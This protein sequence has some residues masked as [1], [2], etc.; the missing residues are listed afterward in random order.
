MAPKPTLSDVDVVIVGNGPS[1]LILS[2]ILHGN[3]PYYDGTNP[4]PDPIL[5]SRLAKSPCLLDA[6]VST[7]TAHFCASRLSYST[8]ALPI[9]VLLDTL[10]RPLAD[11]EPGAHM[12][13]IKWRH[14]P[15]RAITHVVLGSTLKAGGQWADNPVTASWD[16]GTLSYAEMLSLPGYSIEDHYGAT[17]KD[18]PTDYYR[19]SRRE[20]ADYLAAYPRA[21]G[22]DDTIQPSST[23][24]NITRYKNGFSIGSHE[25]YCKHLVLASGIFSSLIPARAQLQPLLKLPSCP[26]KTDAPLLVVGSGFTA[27]DIILSHLPNRKILHI[28]KW[29]PEERPSP[30]QACHPRAYPE[31]AG[32]YRRMK[33]SAM[34]AYGIADAP[35]TTKKQKFNPFFDPRNWENTYEGMPNTYIK[36]VSI[37]DGRGIVSLENEFGYIFH[38]EVSNLEYVIGRRGSL[39][40][41]HKNLRQEVLGSGMLENDTTATISGRSLRSKVEDNLEVAQGVY[42]VGSLTGDSLIRFAFGGCVFAAKEIISKNRQQSIQSPISKT[43]SM[44]HDCKDE[45]NGYILT[46][47]HA[48]LGVDRREIIGDGSKDSSCDRRETL[49]NGRTRF[50][51]DRKGTWTNGPIELSLDGKKG[52]GPSNQEATKYSNRLTRSSCNF[53]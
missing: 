53:L 38:R 2:F 10:I 12:S 31:Y 37:H 32:V 18:L 1:A 6:D 11:T 30:L 36:D 47:G 20:V 33:Y 48:D 15:S 22:I 44:I 25:I 42:V 39:Q 23:V 35:Q 34:K 51:L 50:S 29:S 5:H 14:E 21:V 52:S 4:H 26:T 16:I 45:S 49:L 17:A 24:G 13:C 8:Q 3:I 41:L 40:Y 28:F 46:N 9:N 43:H 27:A 7:L 19:P